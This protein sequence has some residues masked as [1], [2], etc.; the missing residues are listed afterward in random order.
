MKCILCN[1]ENGQ[2]PS[3]KDCDLF[4]TNYLLFK[5]EWEK[6]HSISPAPG[7]KSWK[8]NYC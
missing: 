1:K 5:T 2:S 7:F 3:C 8:K 4:A 6:T